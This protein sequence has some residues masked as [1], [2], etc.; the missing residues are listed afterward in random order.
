MTGYTTTADE[1]LAIEAARG[2][3]QAFDELVYR[4]SIRLR[5]FVRYK[6]PS[7]QDAEDLVQDTFLKAC[8][9]IDR[10]DSSYRFSTWIYT[11][12]YRLAVSRYRSRKKTQ[13]PLEPD[14]SPPV[15]EE[16]VI[17]RDMARRL[18]K[19]AKTLSDSY[20][21]ALWLRYAEDMSIKEMCAVMKKSSAAIRVILHRARISLSRRLEGEPGVHP[22]ADQGSAGQKVS[23]L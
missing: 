18:W 12:A 4:Y 5:H 15:P 10:F 13:V 16:L 14:P 21:Q 8:R 17:Q 11:I 6:V 9:N 3:Q 7:D 20:F 19:I 23:I 2:S 1:A 22:A